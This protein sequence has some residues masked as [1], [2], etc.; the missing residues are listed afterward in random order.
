MF[1]AVLFLIANKKLPKDNRIKKWWYIHTMEYHITMKMK[2]LYVT[3]W[4]NF[5]KLSKRRKIE[6]AYRD[7][8]I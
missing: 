3:M 6:Y 5:I 8:F 4:I 2:Q 7:S 1:I